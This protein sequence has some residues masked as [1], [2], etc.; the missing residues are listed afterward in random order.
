ML[1]GKS[2]QQP[3]A[4][5]FWAPD[6]RLLLLTSDSFESLQLRAPG[7]ERCPVVRIQRLPAVSRGGVCGHC[8]LRQRV[9]W[10]L[11]TGDLVA[12]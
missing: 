9:A 7:G 8:S 5:T 2:R 11:V 3:A 4:L 10:L 6:R 12:V 1:L